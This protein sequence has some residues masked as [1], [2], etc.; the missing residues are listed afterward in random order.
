MKAFYLI[1]AATAVALLS[2]CTVY[3]PATYS[4][5]RPAPHVAYVSPSYVSPSYVVV[6]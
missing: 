5:Y 6:P 2:G 4:Y 3:E 1:T